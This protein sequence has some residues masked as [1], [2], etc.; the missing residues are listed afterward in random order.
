MTAYPCIACC[1]LVCHAAALTAV[2]VL[3]PADRCK[4]LGVPMVVPHHH[5][6][7]LRSARQGGPQEPPPAG[8]AG[9]G[10]SALSSAVHCA[11]PLKTAET[12]QVFRGGRERGR[13][14]SAPPAGSPPCH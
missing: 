11:G 5:G 14:G 1:C 8:H 13:A 12:R 2:P 4:L 9:R 3:K 6:V 7:C 10:E